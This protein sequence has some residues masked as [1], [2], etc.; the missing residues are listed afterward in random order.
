[1]HTSASGHAKRRWY[2]DGV[3]PPIDRTDDGAVPCTIL[4][5][6][7]R[8][9]G[10]SRGSGAQ[11]AGH[12]DVARRLRRRSV[13]PQTPLRIGGSSLHDGVRDSDGKTNLGIDGD[14]SGVDDHLAQGLLGIGATIMSR[15]MLGPARGTRSNDDT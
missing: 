5:A 13:S 10:T 7:E 15:N 14:L 12:G 9:R 3:A 2:L 8:T 1:M 4:E 11:G 6:H